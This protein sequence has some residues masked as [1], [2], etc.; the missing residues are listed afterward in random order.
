MP[1]IDGRINMI[2]ALLQAFVANGQMGV[3]ENP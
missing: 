2:L 3:Q 1:A